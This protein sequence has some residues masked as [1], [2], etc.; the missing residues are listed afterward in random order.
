MNQELSIFFLINRVET[1]IDINSKYNYILLYT[2][3]L[4]ID[5]YIN[6]NNI[7]RD[8]INRADYVFDIKFDQ[9]YYYYPIIFNNDNYK[10]YYVVILSCNINSTNQTNSIDS[11]SINYKMYLYNG[12]DDWNE[13]ISGDEENMLILSLFF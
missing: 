1:D 9:Y 11:L 12:R 8:K 13:Q 6:N 5:N 2:T 3:N 7:C 10:C 4:N